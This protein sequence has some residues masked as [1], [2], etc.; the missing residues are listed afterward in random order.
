[1]RAHT[2]TRG[3]YEKEDKR[4]VGDLLKLGGLELGK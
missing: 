4:A 3:I 1:M 2:V